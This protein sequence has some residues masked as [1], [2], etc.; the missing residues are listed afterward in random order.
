M[1]VDGLKTDSERGGAR[2]QPVRLAVVGESLAVLFADG[3]LHIGSRSPSLVEPK[4][5]M[6]GPQE[7]FDG[8]RAGSL[9]A[10]EPELSALRARRKAIVAE[11]RGLLE[12]A[13][14]S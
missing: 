3:L 4:E 11:M 14:G 7:L 12:R 1:V 2:N 9:R 5:G 6:C 10:A 13:R 8:H